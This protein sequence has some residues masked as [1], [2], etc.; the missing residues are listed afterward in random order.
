[1]IQEGY[2]RIDCDRPNA[3]LYRFEGRL[4]WVAGDK[5]HTFSLKPDNVLL[6]GATLKNTDKILG[7][8]VYVGNETKIMKNMVKS[9]LKF[10]TLQSHLNMLVVSIFV[11]N[12]VVLLVSSLLSGAWQDSTGKDAWYIAWDLSGVEVA[13]YHAATYFVLWTYLIPISLFVSLE[14]VRLAQM[15]F[16]DWDEKMG[17]TI[18]GEWV[19]MKANSSNLNEDLGKIDHVF[20]DKVRGCPP[21]AF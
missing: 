2:G 17:T 13:F 18:D 4:D 5:A 1:M 6:R 11:L 15:F 7:A 8:V 21:I 20:S 9:S 16:M 10:S 12:V 3:H 19:P 14:M